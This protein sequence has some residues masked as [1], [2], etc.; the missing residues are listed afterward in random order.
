[1]SGGQG[2]L[3]FKVKVMLLGNASFRRFS[4][5]LLSLYKGLL[6]FCHQDE[7]DNVRIWTTLPWT[8]QVAGAHYGCDMHTFAVTVSFLLQSDYDDA[9]ASDAY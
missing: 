5:F 9:R 7:S 6:P 1:M 3:R 8:Y 4:C 2:A